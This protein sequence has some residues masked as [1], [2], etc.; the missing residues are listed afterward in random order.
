MRALHLTLRLRGGGETEGDPVEVQRLAQLGE[1]LGIVGA[2]EAVV[3][4]VKFQGQT[5]TGERF[6]QQVEVSQQRFA[7][8]DPG[9]GE[10]A[11]AIV[12]DI[13]H[14]ESVGAAREPAV[15]CGIQ[16]PEFANAAAL[17]AADW[18]R[19]T[20]VGLGMGQAVGDGP[21]TDLRPIELE[22]A[23]TEHFAGGK[24]VGGRWLAPES[25]AQQGF[26][27]GGPGGGVIASRNARLPS[28]LLMLGAG[29]EVVGVELVESAAGEPQPLR[30][31]QRV[32]ALG[33]EVGQ[34]MTD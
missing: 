10:D 28:G 30:R 22:V 14:G 3:I 32:E 24:T 29:F 6:G 18:R 25:F 7:L 23:E 9:A 1:G 20:V 21:A 5:I 34:D 4:D 17:P 11:A 15:G 19:R 31:R 12:Q 16:L 2:E 13:E 33:T 8:V 26:H 27:G